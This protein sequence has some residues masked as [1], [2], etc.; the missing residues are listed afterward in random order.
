[1]LRLLP[2]A[3][4]PI[5]V[6]Q[7]NPLMDDVCQLNII[8]AGLSERSQRALTIYFH[9]FD[10]WVKSGGKVDYR[11]RDGHRRLVEDA[12]RFCGSGNH[13][14]TRHGDLA[15]A[16]LAIDYHDAQIRLIE[17]S[18]PI[19][20]GY[21]SELLSQCADLAE[22]PPEMEKRVGLLMDYLGKKKMP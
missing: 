17:T 22:F 12:M 19:L 3:T 2:D 13:V 8:D 4:F 1:M 9:T 10:L 14:A 21:V 11:G 16:H 7:F 20:P 5:T 15:A 18:K 6:Q